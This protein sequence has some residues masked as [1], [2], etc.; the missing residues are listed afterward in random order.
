M[1]Q[2]E[3]GRGG[4]RAALFAEM[5]RVSSAPIA[6]TGMALAVFLYEVNRMPTFQSVAPGSLGASL[7]NL[8]TLAT[9]LV[10]AV[11]YL[12][13]AQFRLHRHM[14]ACFGVAGVFALTLLWTFGAGT[15]PAPGA[16]QPAVTCV[17]RCCETLM[18][19][20]WAEALALLT[21]RQ[22][23]SV[24]ALSFVI[25][26]AVNAFSCALDQKSVG[27]VVAT[28]PF[29]SLVCLYWFRDRA[30]TMSDELGVGGPGGALVAV[31]RFDRSLIP[32]RRPADRGISS[33]NFLL[34]LLC[35]PVVFGFIHYAW[36]PSQDSG[37]ASTLIQLSAAVGTSLGG[38]V[39][40]LLVAVF[41]GRRKLA[42]YNMFMLASLLMAFAMVG[43]LAGVAPYPY[44]VLLNVAQKIAFFFI[45]MAP[46]LIPG[47]RAPLTVWCLALGLYQC[48]KA[49][50]TMAAG[51]LEPHVYTLLVACTVAAL[52]VGN[53]LGIVLDQ[54][55]LD[56][57]AGG[58]AEGAEGADGVREAGN[59]DGA[60]EDADATGE[61]PDAPAPLD[62]PVAR[63]AAACAELAK[64]FHLSRREEDVLNLVSQGA[65]AHEVAE[66]LVISDSTAKTHMRNLYA[67]MGVHSQTEIVLLIAQTVEGA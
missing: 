66:A 34:P 29:L 13:R 63:S 5:D 52:T 43:F 36:V 50:S 46:F 42:L 64:R 7:L 16:L 14:A 35:C 3:A 6:A 22:A 23:A 53:I 30:A 47:T 56:W 54:G 57:G 51:V 65:V 60:E 48:G 31:D 28:L 33:L 62:A 12:R 61:R 17:M 41:W 27:I 24:A 15:V 4:A 67:K 18:M 49:V 26:G 59:A 2:G 19:L 8:A 9:V 1:P 39:L 25:L 44:I 55:E 32:G 45:W 38:A 11:A 37:L 20:F 21:A 10:C 40:L 58:R